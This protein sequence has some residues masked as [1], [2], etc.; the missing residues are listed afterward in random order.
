MSEHKFKIRQVV[1]YFPPRRLYAPRGAYYVTAELP[2]RLGEFEYRIK[3]PR[4][5]RERVAR[6]RDLSEPWL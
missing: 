4:E 1:E 5:Q 6:E 3:H 2:A